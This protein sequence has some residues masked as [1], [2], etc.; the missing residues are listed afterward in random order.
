MQTRRKDE[1][2]TFENMSFFRR[3]PVD[4]SVLQQLP[5]FT[6]FYERYLTMKEDTSNDQERAN[7]LCDE[8]MYIWTHM[9]IPFMCRK[10]MVSK[11]KKMLAEFNYLKTR[12]TER[13]TGKAY[14]DRLQFLKI[15]LEFGLDLFSEKRINLLK[16]IL[17][18]NMV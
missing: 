13:R 5:T 2:C 11:F 16:T 9:N 10:S 8:F 1:L 4:L 12:T 15:N 17:A 6:Y 3:D 7:N 14:L 18:L